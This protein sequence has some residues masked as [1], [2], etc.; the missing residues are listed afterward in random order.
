MSRK[1]VIWHMET[2]K[3]HKIVKESN[4]FS[5]ILRHFG[6]R[7]IGGNFRTL[8]RRLIKE[9]I[10]FSH[11][12]QGL[13]A[14]RGRS[15]FIK[16]KIPNEK[17]FVKDSKYS[18]NV[19]RKRILK[20]KLLEYKCMICDLGPGWQ[21]Q[22]MTLI[23]DHI[24]GI[25][26]DHQ[27]CNLRFLCPNCNSQT[28]TFGGRN[29]KHRKYYCAKCN[30]SITA[31]SKSGLC[32]PCS[33]RNSHMQRNGRTREIPKRDDLQ[34][35]AWEKP[36]VQIAREFGVSDKAVHKWCKRMNVKKPPLGF[37]NGGIR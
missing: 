35:L 20:E 17:I 9:E 5:N 11:I 33:S 30:I 18:R 2:D 19:V 23:L 36:I 14:N 29:I 1:S 8:K 25:R 4:T 24:N 7:N 6:L 12:P 34:K 31:H 32:A 21:D 27:L 15:T 10:D 22:P 28:S 16:Q 37:W 26:N 13:D 3:L